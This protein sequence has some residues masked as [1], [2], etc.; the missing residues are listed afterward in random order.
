MIDENGRKRSLVLPKWVDLKKALSSNELKYPRKNP[1]IINEFTHNKMSEQLSDYRGDPSFF[2]AVDLMGANFVIGESEVAKELAEHVLKLKRIPSSVASLAHRILGHIENVKT[3]DRLDHQIA[4]LKKSLIKFPKNS[5]NWIDIARIYTIKGQYIKAKRAVKIALNISPFDRYIVRCSTRFFLH[6][7]EPEL[8]WYYLKRALSTAMDPWIIALEVSIAGKLDKPIKRF[9]SYVPDNLSADQIFSYSELIESYGM[10][11]LSAGNIKNAKKKFKIAWTNPSDNVIRHGEWVIRNELPGLEKDA[12][13]DYKKSFEASSF[14]RY[15]KIEIPEALK[16]INEWELEEPYSAG[17]YVLGSHILANI[18]KYSESIETAKK[19]LQT[20]PGHFV[21]TNNLCYS[22]I[23]LG[24][25]YDAEKKLE[26][27]SE[28]AKGND[29]LFY[30]ANRGLLEFKKG[31]IGYGR[32]FYGKALKKC[33]GLSDTRLKEQAYLNLALAEIEANTP[34][35][36]KL[37]QEYLELSYGSIHPSTILLR[38]RLIK[39]I[40][41]MATK[42]ADNRLY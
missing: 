2:K 34:E 5:F 33:E 17:P 26:A 29:I 4:Y 24:Q 42:K 32:E 39:I 35:S 28:L 13:L 11:E 6:I 15:H 10:L 31:K 12:P 41:S 20:N 37:A 18:G 36:Q 8:A 21:L 27:L 1:F 9:A 19:G 38:Y 40:K 23:N 16:Y 22:M 25:L 3:Y 14:H 7:G 30:Y